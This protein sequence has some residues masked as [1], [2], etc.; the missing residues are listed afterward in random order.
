MVGSLSGSNEEFE[1]HKREAQDRARRGQGGREG[2][3][4]EADWEVVEREGRAA[5]WTEEESDMCDDLMSLSAPGAATVTGYGSSRGAPPP[6]PALG[7]APAP[8]PQSR[9]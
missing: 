2:L 1:K 8:A 7:M 5:S 9:S 6:P 4:K 3:E